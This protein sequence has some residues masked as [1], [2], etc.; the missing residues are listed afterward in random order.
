MGWVE[1]VRVWFPELIDTR[2]RQSSWT[3]IEVFHDTIKGLLGEVTVSTI[4]Q[5]LRDEHGLAVS[6]SSLRR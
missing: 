1:L 3:A 4:G 2:L 5:R 6:L